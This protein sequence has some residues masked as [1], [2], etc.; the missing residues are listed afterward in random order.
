MKKKRKKKKK[1]PKAILFGRMLDDFPKRRILVVGDVMLDEYVWGKAS[2][3]SPEAPVPVVEIENRTFHAGGAANTVSNILS[4]GAKADLLGLVGKDDNG[5]ILRDILREAGVQT[6][7]LITDPDRPTTCK[8]RIVAHGQQ[9]MRADHET[10][11]L[12]PDKLADRALRAV[13]KIAD[14]IDGIAVSDYNKGVVSPRLMSGLL[15]IAKEHGKPIT[16]DIKP[17]NA[18]LFRG[19]TLITPNRFEASRMSGIAITGS[20]SLEKAGKKLMSELAVEILLITLGENGMALFTRGRPM[21]IFPVVATRVYD[22]TGAG[23]TVLAIATLAISTGAKPENAVELANIAAGV[24][25]RKRGTTTA[26][27]EEL[28]A[29]MEAIHN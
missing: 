10:T 4:L 1:T 27:A 6:S 24:V 21:R 12:M 15:T 20:D 25:V 26:S 5:K 14:L 13:A 22:V 19:V 18:S 3:I 23:D 2:R 8:V 28:R 29:L 9:V 7:M 16:A 11:G 17:E